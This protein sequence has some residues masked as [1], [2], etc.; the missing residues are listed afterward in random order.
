MAT[1][2]ND[3]TELAVP[4]KNLVALLVAV[5]AGT[6]GYFTAMERI[7]SLEHRLQM[8][9][10]DVNQNSVFRVKWPRGELG[11][12]PADARQD[13]LI[14]SIQSALQRLDNR[15]IKVDDLQVRVKLLEQKT[16]SKK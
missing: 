9:L 10:M 16:E 8:A 1:K 15:L 12:L 3:R 13:L 5:A 6:G 2:V 7:T 11:S 4:I 14:E